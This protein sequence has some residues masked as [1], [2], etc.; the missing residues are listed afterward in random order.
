ML[1]YRMSPSQA[2]TWRCCT[3]AQGEL[4]AALTQILTTLIEGHDILVVDDQDAPLFIALPHG[5]G[6]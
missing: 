6:A 2:H 5:G 1:T 4:A 3:A